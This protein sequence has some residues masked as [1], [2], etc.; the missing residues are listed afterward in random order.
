MT[1]S[2]LHTIHERLLA[3]QR[4][5]LGPPPTDDE[6]FRY[7]DGTLSPADE[8]RVRELLVVYPE[9]A[10][11]VGAPFPTDD[12]QPGDPDYLTAADV[13]QRWN[14]FRRRNAP[15]DVHVLPW[16]RVSFALAAALVIALGGVLWQSVRLAEE[17][18]APRLASDEQL[19]LPDGQRGPASA[20]ATLTARGDR[21]LL[22]APLIN[23]PDFPGYRIDI[24]NVANARPLWSSPVVG[25]PS[26]DTFAIEVPREFFEPGDYRVMT[27]G[28]SGSRQEHLMS[29]SLHVPAAH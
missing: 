2:D 22:V 13:S 18:R 8:A 17:R 11:A 26:N 6:L 24:V 27:Y 10:A 20:G 5:R 7:I 14:E 19:L 21:F 25:R 4:E 1:K 12:A 9:L 16:R 15:D 23:P 29:Y 28:V 3:E